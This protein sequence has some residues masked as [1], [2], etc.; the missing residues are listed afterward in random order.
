VWLVK[1][2]I[3][4]KLWPEFKPGVHSSNWIKSS[5][6]LYLI[7]RYGPYDEYATLNGL[8]RRPRRRAA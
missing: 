5:R 1:Q 3:K 4:L 8:N 2:M 6:M 7:R